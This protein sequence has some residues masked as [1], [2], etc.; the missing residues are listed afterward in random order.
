MRVKGFCL[1][2]VGE[3]YCLLRDLAIARRLVRVLGPE[4]VAKVMGWLGGWSLSTD[5]DI[6][7]A[8]FH[9]SFL[10]T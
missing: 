7:I 1:W 2:G 4:G 5:G 9:I 8:I 10:T 6:R 3:A